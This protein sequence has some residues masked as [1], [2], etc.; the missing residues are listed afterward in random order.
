[1]RIGK[2]MTCLALAP[3]SLNFKGVLLQ[4]KSHWRRGRD[5]N[6]RWGFPHAGFQDR[7][8]QPLGHLSAAHSVRDSRASFE[9]PNRRGA[10]QDLHS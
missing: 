5:S 1:M 2:L 3:K 10:P 4:E 7:S 9:L 8:H 6:P